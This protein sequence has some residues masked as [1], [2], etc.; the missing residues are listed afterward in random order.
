MT[1][2]T[3]AQQAIFDAYAHATTEL[4]ELIQTK[5][6]GLNGIRW[7]CSLEAADQLNDMTIREFAEFLLD[8]CDPIGELTAE[9]CVAIC[10]EE[11]RDMWMNATLYPDDDVQ[12]DQAYLDKRRNHI[13]QF[14]V[15]YGRNNPC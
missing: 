6:S 10:F 1:E 12:F 4:L 9:Q 11:E 3:P 13:A 15:E 2:R 8:G 7:L 5:A 14:L